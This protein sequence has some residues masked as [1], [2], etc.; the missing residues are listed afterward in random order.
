[1]YQECYF[2]GATFKKSVD[3]SETIFQGKASF[4]DITWGDNAYMKMHNGSAFLGYVDMTGEKLENYLFINV[5]GLRN[6]F[7][8]LINNEHGDS[9]QFLQKWSNT[10]RIQFLEKLNS[11]SLKTIYKTEDRFNEF[12][13]KIRKIFTNVKEND[14][15]QK[16]SGVKLKYDNP[17]NL[18]NI[19]IEMYIEARRAME[20]MAKK[21]SSQNVIFW[22][23]KLKEDWQV[24]ILLNGFGLHFLNI[25][26]GTV[27]LLSEYLHLSFLIGLFFRFYTGSLS[28]GMICLV[29]NFPFNIRTKI[30]LRYIMTFWRV[31]CIVRTICFL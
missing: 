6:I 27:N 5:R 26:Q 20:D 24:G 7:Y 19:E 14:K 23:W 16:V 3:L 29:L 9:L 13:F 22:K 15:N 12:F 2:E 17:P 4:K 8:S 25:R 28:K 11:P 31:L 1:M 30:L 10:C 18:L 21:N